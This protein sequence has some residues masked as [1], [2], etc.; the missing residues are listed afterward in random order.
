[1]WSG[2]TQTRRGK[3]LNQYFGIFLIT[4]SVSVSNLTWLHNCEMQFRSHYL[5]DI[6]FEFRK[7]GLLA[8]GKEE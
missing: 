2:I 8:T 3:C 7:T 6:K 1:M 4:I 5:R